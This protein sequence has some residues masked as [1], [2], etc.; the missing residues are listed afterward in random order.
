M[1][2]PKPQPT[3]PNVGDVFPLNVD[4]VLDEDDM[5]RPKTPMA[6]L[7]FN[8]GRWQWEQVSAAE[9][10][11]LVFFNTAPE[12]GVHTQFRIVSIVPNGRACYAEPVC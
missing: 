2:I 5:G 9:A 4:Q 7:R 1:N 8:T 10:G 12:I 11:L 6:K 3:V